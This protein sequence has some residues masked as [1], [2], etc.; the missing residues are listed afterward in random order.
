[1][2]TTT[3]RDEIATFA[4]A[5]R[6]H[7][8][9]LPADEVDDLT[10]G[11]EADLFEQ[12]EDNEGALTATDPAEYASELRTSAG[13]PERSDASTA[14]TLRARLSDVARQA[15]ARMS[16]FARSSR[17]GSWLTDLLLAVRPV[18]W[19][20]RGWAVFV[21][22]WMLWTGQSRL[23]PTALPAWAALVGVV[24]VSIQWGRGRWLPQRWLKAVRLLMSV[25]AVIASPFLVA[26]ALDAV[27]N[28][29]DVGESY[30]NPSPVGLTLDGNRVTNIFGYD[31]DGRPLDH[32]QLFTQDGKP[33][34]TVGADS[35]GLDSDFDA[36]TDRLP[37]PYAKVGDAYVWNV[38][39]L[40]EAPLS[41]DG[42]VDAGRAHDATPPLQSTTPL[43]AYRQPAPTSGQTS[44]ATPAPSATP[45]ARADPA[46]PPA[47]SP[48]PS[49]AVTP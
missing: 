40:R 8:D 12:A 19:V 43:S 47:P 31:A 38:F 9:D 49:P 13:L 22:T 10:E 11:L 6:A 28:S 18:W 21:V 27:T 7:L 46:A 45:T 16:G 1:M 29:V 35:T 44:M 25:V 32:I 39:P 20:Y 26:G 24:L 5:V 2:P 34:V 15:R 41:A 36:G 37:V 3:L 30:A 14:P 33:L 42:Q 48:V 17:F 4:A 23:L